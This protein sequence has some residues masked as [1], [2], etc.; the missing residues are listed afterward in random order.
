MLIHSLHWFPSELFSNL[1]L[2]VCI[3]IFLLD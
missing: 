3:A 2:A 1:F